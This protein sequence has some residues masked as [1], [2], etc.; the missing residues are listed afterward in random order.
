[1]VL[2]S[3]ISPTNCNIPTHTF[4]GEYRSVDHRGVRETQHMRHLY[5]ML[6]L[7]VWNSA[8]AFCLHASTRE[9]WT[10]ESTCKWNWAVNKL[11]Q[12]MFH[13]IQQ[14]VGENMTRNL[15]DPHWLSPNDIWLLGCLK[16]WAFLPFTDWLSD[17]IMHFALNL[18][19]SVLSQTWEQTEPER[20][21]WSFHTDSPA[22]S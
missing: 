19:I 11:I 14:L 12:R 2:T 17:Q 13:S 22:P 9:C 21:P 20:H 10:P 4:S 18:Y 1:M 15:C 6:S 16:R 7:D 3:F 5:E 8:I